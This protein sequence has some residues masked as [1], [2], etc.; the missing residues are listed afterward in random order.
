MKKWAATWIVASL[1]GLFHMVVV[2]APVLSS[3]GIGE[4][5]GFAVGIFDMPLVWFVSALGGGAIL[6]GGHWY[7]FVFSVV[8]TFMYAVAGAVGGLLV[9]R[10]RLSFSRE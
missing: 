2:T 3:H 1:C 5:Q 9:D 7:V 8:G 10:L 4:T 6:N